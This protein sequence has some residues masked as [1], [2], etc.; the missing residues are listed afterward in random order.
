MPLRPAPGLS[1]T[2]WSPWFR[3]CLCICEHVRVTSPIGI[4]SVRACAP[5]EAVSSD[6]CGF[7][8]GEAQADNPSQMAELTPGP[9][10]AFLGQGGLTR[11]E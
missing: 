2:L 6:L 3:M 5:G 7:Q 8:Q 1:T 4:V 11:A 10:G 9:D